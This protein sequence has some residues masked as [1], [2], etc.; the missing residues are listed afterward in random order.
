[1]DEVADL[2]KLL[3]LTPESFRRLQTAPEQPPVKTDVEAPNEDR[4]SIPCQDAFMAPASFRPGADFRNTRF[5][6]NR[7]GSETVVTGSGV[8]GG[9]SLL[10]EPGMGS[11]K[12][13][14]HRANRS[15][16]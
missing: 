13:H 1:M 7:D 12:S 10:A 16:R 6:D 5:W 8:R 4:V 3:L 15:R 2:H 9:S 14:R 11:L